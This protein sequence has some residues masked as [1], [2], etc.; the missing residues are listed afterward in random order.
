MGEPFIG[1]DAVAS[2]RLTPYALRSRF[3]AIHPDIYL[4]RD[5]RITAAIRAQAAWLWSRRRGVI[6]GQ[7]AAAL[8]GAKWVDANRPAEMLYG[9]RHQPAGIRTWADR[10]EDDEVE[11][12]R[13]VR[14]TTPERTALDIACRYRLDPAVAAIDALARATKLKIADVDVLVQRYAGRRGIKNAR[15][16]LDLV[17]PGAESPRETGL[18]LMLIRAGFPRPQT[19]IP[20]YDEYGV[21][22]AILDLGWEDIKV[23]ADYDGDHHR[24]D[25]NRFYHDIRR[26]ETITELG[27]IDVRVT[28]Q[29]TPGSIIRRVTAARARRL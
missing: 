25:R 29:D 6:A 18:R 2:G 21:L 3:I 11:T 12:V 13:G 7:S 28:S 16:A 19:Q 27:W 5:A 1:S 17:D 15:A 10:I 22:V 23:A 20:V 9:N 24:T 26:A 14:A 4:P 8:H